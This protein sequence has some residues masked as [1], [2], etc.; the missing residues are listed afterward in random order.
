MHFSWFVLL[1]KWFSHTPSKHRMLFAMLEEAGGYITDI[2]QWYTLLNPVEKST[3]KNH[4]KVELRNLS[5]PTYAQ[6]KI[7]LSFSS[8]S[9]EVLVWPALKTSKDGDST[10]SMASLLHCLTTRIVREFFLISYPLLQFK[11]ISLCL[12][13]CSHREYSITIFFT[14]TRQVLESCYQIPLH[15]SLVQTK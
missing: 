15:F 3:W 2:D 1:E 7:G 8:H 14:T 5:S 11:T 9:R 10:T 4:R 12:V 13:L 6:D